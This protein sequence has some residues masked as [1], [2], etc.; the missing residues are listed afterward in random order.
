MAVTELNEVQKTGWLDRMQG[1]FKGITTG[2]GVI[3]AGVALLF[4]NEGRAVKTAKA[5]EEGAGAVVSVK[6]DQVDPANE[7]KLVHV[8]GKADTKEMLE[9]ADFGVKVTALRLVRKTEIFQWVETAKTR[10]IKKGDKEYEETTYSYKQ[11][12]CSKPVDSSAFKDP[13]HANP[14][15]ELQFPDARTYAQEATLGAF[16]LSERIVKNVG[17]EITYAFPT[18]YALPASMAGAQLKNNTVYIPAPKA[19][20]TATRVGAGASPLLA[21]AQAAVS[22]AVNVAVSNVVN[23]VLQRDVALTPQIGDVR[24]RF[25]V[26][27]PKDISLCCQQ[28]DETFQPWKAS[29]GKLIDLQSD[30]VKSAEEMFASAQSSNKIWTWVVRVLGFL[31]LSG[32]F[33]GLFG[34]IETLVDVI[35]ILNGLVSL[36][37][38]LVSKLLAAVVWLLTVGIAWVFYRPVLGISL[39]VVAVALVVLAVM[40][41]KKTPAP[42]P[43]A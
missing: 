34:P 10:K 31:M 15:A 3:V 27:Y 11:E 12:W 30:G 37:V 36:G 8:S 32:G 18:N 14:F 7:G 21:A 38:G 17:G 6:A 4:W 23:G 25:F 20:E 22:N 43:A 33:R 28:R 40:R 39:I 2:L 9:D 13:K 5:L 24:V 19:V 26:V 42:T 1:S 35:P 41:K 16:R 29:N